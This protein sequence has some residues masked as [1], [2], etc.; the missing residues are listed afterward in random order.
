MF[1]ASDRSMDL[2]YGDILI[3]DN[4]VALTDYYGNFEYSV[5]RDG[6][7]IVLAF[8]DPNRDLCRRT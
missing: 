1:F 5:P 7:R 2:R 3:D 8:R 4:N 6:K